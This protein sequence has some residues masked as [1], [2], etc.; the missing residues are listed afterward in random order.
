MAIIPV[1]VILP[2]MGTH[3]LAISATCKIG[4]F[5]LARATLRAITKSV[6]VML[7]AMEKKF[8]VL[9]LLPATENR[10]VR[11]LAIRCVTDIHPAPV[12]VVAMPMMLANV[13]QLVM[14]MELVF[15][16]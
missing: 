11:A 1:F 14:D 9:V 10:Q 12:I 16:M 3:A 4:L 2:V 6:L 7:R 8:P 13:I 5:L 15:V